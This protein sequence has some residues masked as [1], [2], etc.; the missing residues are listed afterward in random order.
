MARPKT[1][2]YSDEE[3]ARICREILTAIATGSSLRA[4]CKV[5][6]RVPYIT[7]YAWMHVD[8]ELAAR[9]ARATELRADVQ[10]EEILEI[11]DETAD[12]YKRDKDGNLVPDQEVIARSKLRIDARKWLMAKMK[13]KKYG[14]KIAVEGD[15]DK[16]IV[17]EHRVIE[18]KRYLEL[19]RQV[20]DEY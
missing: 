12:D 17:H 18:E 13:P 16:P 10:A 6:G 9:Y 4:A 3:K 19:T 5:P 2:S 11:A 20:L 8:S 7:F 15:A 1:T 14:E